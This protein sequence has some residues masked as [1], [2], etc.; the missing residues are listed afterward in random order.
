MS[1][2]SVIKFFVRLRRAMLSDTVSAVAAVVL[3]LIL[4]ISIF[5]P[6]LPIGKPDQ[7]GFGPRLGG[8]SWSAPMGTDQLGRSVLARVLQGIQVTFLLSTVS[9]AI[10]GLAG[11]LV[12]ISATYFHRFADEVASRTADVMFAFPPILLGFLVVAIFRPGVTSAM[13]VIA[14]ITFPTM[15][16]VVRASTLSVM[17]RDFMLVAE[18]SGVSFVD[19]VFRHLLPNVAKVIVVQ[20]IYS[21]SLGMLIES[22]LSFLGLGVQPPAASLGSLLRDGATYL[23]IAPWL[24]IGP[25]IILAFSIMSINLV[26]DATRSF[27]DP[28][29][30]F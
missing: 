9:V 29:Y 10:A 30:R 6:F 28:T 23:E 21:I 17:R 7:I 3:V 4:L 18:I 1:I 12:G 27:V 11:A 25:G 19:R 8:W 24:S 13:A 14:L 22:S 15:L 20:T 16:R 2:E 26:G 5:G